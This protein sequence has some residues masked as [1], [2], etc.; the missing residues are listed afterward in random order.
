MVEAKSE[1][2]LTPEQLAAREAAKQ[3]K[4]DEA[5]SRKRELE[6]ANVQHSK[7]V[8]MVRTMPPKQNASPREPEAA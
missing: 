1:M 3:R 7:R 5:D 6:N 2:A 4:Q 8:S